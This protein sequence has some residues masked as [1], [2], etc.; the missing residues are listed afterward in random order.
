MKVSFLSII[1]FKSRPIY[2]ILFS[3]AEAL[4]APAVLISPALFPVGDLVRSIPDTAPGVPPCHSVAILGSITELR[5]DGFWKNDRAKNI[6]FNRG[7]QLITGLLI[8]KKDIN[9]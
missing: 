6:V 2:F 7:D 3:A 1:K 4:S 9:L 8:T 5:I